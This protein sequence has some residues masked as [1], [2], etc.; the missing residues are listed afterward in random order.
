MIWSLGLLT[1]ELLLLL[2]IVL[3]RVG[4]N[5]DSA[6]G[7]HSLLRSRALWL[8]VDSA[9]Y[10]RWA[11]LSLFALVRPR[12]SAKAFA[13]FFG[14]SYTCNFNFFFFT[15]AGNFIVSQVFVEIVEILVKLS[16]FNVEAYSRT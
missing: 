14:T 6:F 2:L 16:A 8:I 12:Y 9:V 1:T 11:A 4:F 3:A 13:F 7:D 10:L 5:E 15:L